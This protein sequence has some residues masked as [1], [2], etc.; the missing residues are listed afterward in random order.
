MFFFS[1]HVNY[2]IKGKSWFANYDSLPYRISMTQIVLYSNWFF[3]KV[4]LF[5]IV[6]HLN[7]SERVVMTN[8]SMK[9]LIYHIF[10]YGNHIDINLFINSIL[11]VSSWIL[12]LHFVNFLFKLEKL[13]TSAKFAFMHHIATFPWFL[14]IP[15]ETRS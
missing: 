7:R 6:R 5:V 1:K 15:P 8:R 13:K 14:S 9:N 2:S 4:E 10:S 3:T 12:H 11:E